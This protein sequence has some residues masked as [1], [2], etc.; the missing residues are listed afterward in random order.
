LDVY[1]CARKCL[2]WKLLAKRVERVPGEHS[3]R[4]VVAVGH[5]A[6]RFIQAH[7]K[8]LRLLHPHATHP[9]SARARKRGNWRAG[10]REDGDSHHLARENVLVRAPKECGLE[11]LLALERFAHGAACFASP[12]AAGLPSQRGR[13]SEH[14]QNPRGEQA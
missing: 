11:P 8:Q 1:H 4:P 5:D 2:P 6:S 7:L 9:M 14:S 13:S 10:G 3:D 12:T